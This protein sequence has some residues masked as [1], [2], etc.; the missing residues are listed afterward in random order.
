M[1]ELG[2]FDSIFW[3]VGIACILLLIILL[4]KGKSPTLTIS[5]I[6]SAVVI[7]VNLSLAVNAK[8]MAFLN[9]F[10]KDWTIISDYVFYFALLIDVVSAV[11]ILFFSKDTLNKK[12]FGAFAITNLALVI[13]SN[14][15][16]FYTCGVNYHLITPL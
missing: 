13:A 12:L 14:V 8:W 15:F 5:G 3:C 16:N 6:L 4:I 1:F 2:F 7:A 9:D 10:V 11:T